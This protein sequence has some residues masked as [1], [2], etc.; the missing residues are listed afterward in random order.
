MERW[1]ALCPNWAIT[2]YF[3][4]IFILNV[5]CSYYGFSVGSKTMTI[6]TVPIILL[7]YFYKQRIMATIF[8]VMFLLYFLGNIFSAIDHFSLTTKLSESFFT[9]AY[10][11][12]V[13]V[14]FGKLKDLKLESFVSWYLIVVFFIS[15]Y[16]IYLMFTGLK[17]SFQDAVILALTVSKGVVLLVM[18]FLA[19]FI[20]LSKETGQSIIF[21]MVICSFIFSDILGFITTFYIQFWFFEAVQRVFQSVGLFMACIYVYNHHQPAKRIKGR[22]TFKSIS[23]S[24]QMSVAS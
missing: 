12:M 3:F 9:G 20:Y 15:T 5:L 23:P 8:S 6:S 17:D 4:L 18:A 1:H 16:F 14:M 11:L 7:F 10:L 13:F 19:F 22:K 24:T 2:L 21:L